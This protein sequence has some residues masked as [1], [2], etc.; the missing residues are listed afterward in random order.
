MGSASRMKRIGQ[1][2][3]EI[4]TADRDGT[5]AA[6]LTSFNG[7]FV[8]GPRWS[9]DGQQ[10]LFQA[11][12]D[13]RELH[14]ISAFGGAPRRL[15]NHPARDAAQNWSR[16]GKWIYFGSDR[17]G[18]SQVWKMP[19]TGGDAVQVTRGGG[20]IA[21]ES[22]D[23]KVL[24]YAK[25]G[26]AQ[27]PIWRMPVLGGEEQPFLPPILNSNAWAVTA[28]GIYFIPAQRIDGKYALQF[29][30]FAT[31]RVRTI[32]PLAGTPQH[33]LSI[34]PDCTTALL[35]QREP[36]EADIM[37]VEKFNR[38][39]SPVRTANIRLEQ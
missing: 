36:S 5:N 25:A 8:G 22:V 9:P 28:R 20:S 12:V 3:R 18:A 31:S 7:P 33:G 13:S 16:D 29:H 32:V 26:P 27:T 11:E 24:Y 15:T 23:G 35:C 19:A 17:S 1:G 21:M 37:L 38:S 4:W 30:D 14:V 6:R 10:I 2:S 39:R 34:S